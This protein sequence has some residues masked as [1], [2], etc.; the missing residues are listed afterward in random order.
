MELSHGLRNDSPEETEK[1]TNG[2]KLAESIL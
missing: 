2:R 1:G